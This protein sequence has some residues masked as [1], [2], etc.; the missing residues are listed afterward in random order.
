M[1]GSPPTSDFAVTA[2]HL[3]VFQA[4]RARLIA[5]AYRMLGSMSDAEDAL[6]EGWV[7][8][9]QLGPQ[10]RDDVDNPAAWFTTVVS[11][12]ALDRLKSAQRQREEYIGPWLPEPVL[13][14]PDPADSA[15]L[16]ESL[17]LGFLTVLERL[18]PVE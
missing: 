11:R 2:A 15:E 17:T 1:S 3:A 8:W 18:G 14:S 4:E 7:R 16:A 12:L 5:F 6:Q 13:T 9:Q 10:R